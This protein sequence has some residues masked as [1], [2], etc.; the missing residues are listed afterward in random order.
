MIDRDYYIYNHLQFHI[1]LN[2]V[3]DNRYNVVGFNILPMSIK[4]DNDKPQCA[5]NLKKH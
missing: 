5:T 2:K 4:H 1:L 3:D